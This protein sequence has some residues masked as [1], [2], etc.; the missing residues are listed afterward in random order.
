MRNR[1][2]MTALM[3]VAVLGQ[4][5]G[6]VAAREV[7]GRIS[8]EDW[9]RAH[10]TDIYDLT[11]RADAEARIYVSGDGDTDLDLYVYDSSGN[12]VAWD[13]DLTDECFASWTPRRTGRFRV[14]VVNRGPLYN[15][16]RLLTN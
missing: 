4:T 1:I 13:V 5:A 11:F 9:V 12:L 7:H 10:H 2:K 15:R 6:V 16:Y 3:L 8:H 14:E